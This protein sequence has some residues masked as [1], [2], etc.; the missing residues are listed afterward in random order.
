MNT[1]WNF[2]RTRAQFWWE[3]AR[4]FVAIERILSVPICSLPPCH[5]QIGLSRSS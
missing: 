2:L 1:A 5:S 4:A 3:A